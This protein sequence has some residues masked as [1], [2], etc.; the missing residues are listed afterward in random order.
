LIW[1]INLSVKVLTRQWKVHVKSQV[2][3]QDSAY[4]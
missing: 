2:R 4:P 3:K 1:L